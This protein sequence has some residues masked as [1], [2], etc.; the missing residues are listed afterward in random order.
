M[1]HINIKV[2]NKTVKISSTTSNINVI[3]EEMKDF[4]TSKESEY[5]IKIL[6]SKNKKRNEVINKNNEDLEFKDSEEIT[7]TKN[8]IVIRTSFLDGNIKD[9]KASFQIKESK[10]T[11]LCIRNGIRNCYMLWFLKDMTAMHGVGIVRNKKGYLFCGPAAE[12]KTTIGKQTK[13]VLNDEFIFVKKEKKKVYICGTPF[14][15]EIKPQNKKALL[16]KVFFIKQSNKTKITKLSD[17]EKF[18]NT[19]KNNHLFM[20]IIAKKEKYLMKNIFHES[21]N[22]INNILC[23]ELQFTLKEDFWRLIDEQ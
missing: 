19:I 6:D 23:Y 4:I 12:G 7:T 17:T 3:K 5:E 8:K 20:K 1:N 18:L 16:N 9:K 2:A 11:Y 13:N 21:K 14:G 15:G 10:N 22:M